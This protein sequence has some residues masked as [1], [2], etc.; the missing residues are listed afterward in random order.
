LGWETYLPVFVLYPIV[1][2]ILSKKYGW[3]N[4]QEKLFGKI[5]KPTIITEE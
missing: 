3:K 4:W 5:E 1:L 2:L